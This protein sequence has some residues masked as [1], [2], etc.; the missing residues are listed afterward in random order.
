MIGKIETISHWLHVPVLCTI[1]AAKSFYDLPI[2]GWIDIKPPKNARPSDR[3]CAAMVNGDS[4]EGEGIQD[5][6]FVVIRTTFEAHEIR[7]GK[8][9]AVFTSYGL[10]IKHIYVGLND[11]VRLVSANKAYEDI[12]L[13][14]EDVKIQGIVVQLVRNL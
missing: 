1:G 13:D 10:L 11:K 12:V 6:D 7:P 9:V 5:G 8:L 2:T 3:F 4:L 14:A